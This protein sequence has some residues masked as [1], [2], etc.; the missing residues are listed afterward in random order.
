MSAHC[1]K[2]KEN[3]HILDNDLGEIK[4]GRETDET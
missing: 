4:P 2:V 3:A 1:G